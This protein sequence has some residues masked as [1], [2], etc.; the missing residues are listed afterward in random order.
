MPV[1]DRLRSMLSE[2]PSVCVIGGA[3]S[4]ED[5]VAGIFANRPDM[6]VLDIHLKSGSGLDVLRRVKAEMPNLKVMV[7]TN[8]AYPQYRRKCEELGVDWFM[9]KS[10]DSAEVVEIIRTLATG[11]SD[12][13]EKPNRANGR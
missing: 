12:Q 8:H 6:A 13:I 5:A 1:M 11:Y 10:G 3:D 9:D 2:I 4:E 7:L